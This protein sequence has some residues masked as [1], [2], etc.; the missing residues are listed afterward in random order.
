[1]KHKTLVVGIIFLFIVS[2]VT[3]VVISYD[4]P[5]ENVEFLEKIAHADYDECNSLDS[6]EYKEQLQDV[7]FDAGSSN[8]IPTLK[9]SIVFKHSKIFIGF[10]FIR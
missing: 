4:E 3:P 1:M 6:K 7:R 5:K 2:S 8:E 10:F 9:I